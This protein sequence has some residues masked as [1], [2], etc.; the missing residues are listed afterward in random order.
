MRSIKVNEIENKMT[1]NKKTPEERKEARNTQLKILKSDSLKNLVIASAGRDTGKY[2]EV[3]E[4]ATHDINYLSSLSNPDKHVGNIIASS[5]LNAEQ[6][7]GE[8]YGGAVTPLHLLKTAE[9]FYFSGLN[10]VKVSDILELM[11]SE[12]S[13]ETI[14]KKDR[15][16]Y[17]ED[18]KENNGDAYKKL[19][20]AYMS[21]IEMTGVGKAITKSGEGIGKNLE[22]ILTEKEE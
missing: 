16:M 21:Y 19:L 12:V 20:S 15:E 10:K 14:S 4:K 7:A 6:E 9:A 3:G 18:F 17:M 2:G 1:Q 8:L 11:E 22:K 13:E 5:F